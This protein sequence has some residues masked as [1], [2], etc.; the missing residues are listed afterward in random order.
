MSANSSSSFG[1]LSQQVIEACG[2]ILVHTLWEF[3]LIAAIAHIAMM[4]LRNQS[5]E[6]RYRT[7]LGFF[8]L[9]AVAP[10]VTLLFLQPSI[11]VPEQSQSISKS[12]SEIDHAN[13]E[14]A[15]TAP[16]SNGQFPS[17]QVEVAATAN[18]LEE[19]SKDSN[20]QA[21]SSSRNQSTEASN[22]QWERF[23]ALVAPH[24]SKIV[25]GW[26]A[27][28]LLFSL[29]PFL[30]WLY[31]RRL[32]R[33]HVSIANESLQEKLSALIAR[34]RIRT[35]TSLLVSELVSVPMVVGCFRSFILL[36]SALVTQIPTHQ[37]EAILAHELAHIRR[38]DYIVNLFQTIVETFC[39]YHPAVWWLSN[40]VRVERENCCDDDSVRV[41]G[42]RVEYGRALLAIQE[43][44]GSGSPLAL[45]AKG[46]VLLERVRRILGIKH[47]AT[48]AMSWT[49]GLVLW[50]LIGLASSFL[51]LTLSTQDAKAEEWGDAV[52]GLQF[53]IVTLDPSVTDEMPNLASLDSEFGSDSELTIGIQL[54]NV[55]D[56][57][58]KLAGIR[59]GT[60]FAKEV[61]GTLNTQLYA[62]HWFD[63]EYRDEKGTLIRFPERTLREPAMIVGSCAIQE[64]KPG[65]TLTEVLRPA[66]FLAPFRNDLASGKYRLRVRYSGPQNEFKAFI[67]KHWPDKEF[68]KAWSDT[69]VS[70]EVS[71]EIRDSNLAKPKVELAWGTPLKG[72]AAAVELRP[73]DSIATNPHNQSGV[74]LG[75]NLETIVHVRNVSL[76]PISFI[77]EVG[78]QGDTIELRDES[79]QEIEV[80]YTFY[81]GWPI[82]VAWTLKPGESA[83][84]GILSPA[85]TVESFAKPGVFKLKC[86]LRFNSR[87]QKNEAGEVIFPRKEDYQEVL[88]TGTATIYISEKPA[89][90]DSS[91]LQIEAPF[92]L[93]DHWIIEDLCWVNEGRELLT[94]SL[95][96][97]V[98]V[99]R[100]DVAGR[101]L[102]SEIK[103]QSDVHG[104]EINQG[105]LR[106]SR[107][108]KRIF[109]VTDSYLGMWDADSGILLKQISIPKEDW[110]YDTVRSLDCNSDG[111]IVFAGLGTRYEKLTLVYDGYGVVWNTNTGET[112]ANVLHENG[113]YFRD[114][115]ISNDGKR[116]VTC[117]EHG[118]SPAVWDLATGKKLADLSKLTNDWKSP[119]EELISNNLITGVAF[120][121]NNETIA[122]AGTYG[123][124]LAEATTGK[125]IRT[126]DAP[127]RYSSG[128]GVPVKFSQD[129]KLIYRAGAQG[130]KEKYSVPIWSVDSGELLFEV[131]GDAETA[132]LSPDGNTLATGESDFWESVSI[133]PLRKGVPLKIDSEPNQYS[134]ENRVEENTHEIGDAAKA[135][136]EKW[137]P[138]WGKSVKGFEYGIALTK[139]SNQFAA[140]E[141][142][143]MAAFVRN[144]SDS[145]KR[146]SLTPDMFGNGPKLMH[147]SK[148]EAT[149]TRQKLLG[150]PSLYRDTLQ[151]GE[152][153]GPLYFNV[154][155]GN[156]PT[157]GR[158]IWTPYWEVPKL[159]KCN[160][161]HQI[162]LGIA[163]PSSDPYDQPT[164]DEFDLL[165]GEITFEVVA[166]QP[167]PQSS[168]R[169]SEGTE[170]VSKTEAEQVKGTVVDE[171]GNPVSGF[172]LISTN[173]GI[174]ATSDAKGEFA[175]NRKV[176]SHGAMHGYS[177]KHL[178]WYGAPEAGE[179][180]KIVLR[181][182]K[183]DLAEPG[184]RKLLVRVH[185]SLT[186][187]PI[188]N[189]TV[190]ATC[191]EGPRDHEKGGEGVTDQNGVATLEGLDPI[192]HQ[193]TTTSKSPLPY[194]PSSYHPSGDVEEVIVLLAPAC[195]LVLR[196]VDNETGVGIPGVTF[197]RENAAGEYWANQISPDIMG[198]NQSDFE[199]KTDKK[200]YFR[201]LVSSAHW[202]YMVGS[203]P[204]GYSKIVPIDGRSELE[205]ETPPGGK[206]EYTFRLVK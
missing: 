142:V 10:L 24:L 77:S 29:R 183:T 60:G 113:Y 21:N 160:V 194:I 188:P 27:G 144:A 150:K 74:P 140:G 95:Q 138:T 126:I 119:N 56:A 193:I 79:G 121:P 6:I 190:V 120:S 70:N 156:D 134:R 13:S 75:T 125:L 192:S 55:S 108:G 90:P 48:S 69:V 201:C 89:K 133:W 101:K 175:F 42:N 182:K 93:Q 106:I 78:R 86:Q 53:R 91:A 129:G 12:L 18:T 186:A 109:G 22:S 177:T 59:Y 145:P 146:I 54:K 76:K 200:G 139:P 195:E 58:I 62:P 88:E 1:T 44:Q 149:L 159:G 46:G 14:P 151:P 169:F 71:F 191:W 105:S 49:F 114:I 117:N 82:D 147:E 64:L 80:P 136:A 166:T 197:D 203:F 73:V 168:R 112:I 167:T 11:A 130:I 164:W 35:P 16:P 84:L 189:V 155:L 8:T 9:I 122:I 32:I 103:L 116:V 2:W 115:A 50:S 7:L 20:R 57:P 180:L 61:Q 127:Y 65:E 43:L 96:G 199:P 45:Q 40:Q 28:V 3:L 141:R 181:S 104:R 66:K 102:L 162:K 124:K 97:G 179:E 185:D 51:L 37:L 4:L 184:K 118:G 153:F 15:A 17:K 52:A 198:S 31:V 47:Q 171:N 39:F 131:G 137:K 132:R 67:D 205:L 135:Y 152:V 81:T 25:V 154:G 204:N 83:E 173:G 26:L 123:I 148:E 111:S 170:V 23:E 174:Y 41:I 176:G 38:R 72:L 30:G 202:S 19:F 163:P 157:S 92:R 107:N 206:V 94:V 87:T 187:K 161:T 196:A 33:E 178:P 68:G 63:L 158:Q 98:N 143:T 99:R 36:P 172:E 85:V 128:W 5:A 34:M 165:S 100:W 110:K